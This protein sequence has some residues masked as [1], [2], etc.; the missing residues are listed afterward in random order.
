MNPHNLYSLLVEKL[1]VHET[2]PAKE[3]FQ[4]Q[5]KLK[6]NLIQ[7]SPYLSTTCSTRYWRSTSAKRLF[8]RSTPSPNHTSDLKTQV[9]VRPKKISSYMR[10]SDCHF[11]QIFVSNIYRHHHHCHILGVSIKLEY[12][13]PWTLLSRLSHCDMVVLVVTIWIWAEIWNLGFCEDLMVGRQIWPQN[14]IHPQIPFKLL[15]NIFGYFI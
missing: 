12:L 14:P 8:T 10:S 7:A 1:L 9:R 4:N 15:K 11:H 5:T 2:G 13:I 3:N 6:T